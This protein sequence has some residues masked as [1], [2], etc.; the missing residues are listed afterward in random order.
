MRPKKNQ[1]GNPRLK[2]DYGTKKKH[3]MKKI[4]TNKKTEGLSEG[5]LEAS[6]G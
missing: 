3:K 1:S 6:L 2:E 5:R 4:K